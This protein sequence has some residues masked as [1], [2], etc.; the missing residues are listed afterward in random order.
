MHPLFQSMN[1][2]LIWGILK[3]ITIK[4][5]MVLKIETHGY[6]V[7]GVDIGNHSYLVLGSVQSI[8]PVACSHS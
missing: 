7:I 1:E 8:S 6:P 4:D 3:R 5:S 2:F